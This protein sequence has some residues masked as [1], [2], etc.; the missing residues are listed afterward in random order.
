MYL[1]GGPGTEGCKHLLK[2]IMDFIWEQC[3]FVG[4]MHYTSLISGSCNA[5]PPSRCIAQA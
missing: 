3:K 2:S 1:T 4:Q 5:L